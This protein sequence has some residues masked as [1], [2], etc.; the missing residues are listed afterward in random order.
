[1]TKR[2]TSYEPRLWQPLAAAAALLLVTA[3]QTAAQQ[4]P[5]VAQTLYRW[6]APT[7]ADQL[8]ADPTVGPA[9]VGALFVPAMTN[10]ID[11]PEAL[12]YQGQQQVASGANGR[13]I[14]LAPGSYT[15]RVGSPPLNQMV[16]VPVEV[17]A[18]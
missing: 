16:T 10:G 15:L 9:G 6:T 2:R 13:R 3:S 14:V 1:M 11:E 18:G 4:P 7:A 12:V 8:A 17:T 5:D